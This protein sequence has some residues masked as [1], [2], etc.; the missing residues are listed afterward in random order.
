MFLDIDVN[1]KVV[2][3]QFN[4]A[5]NH[6]L[7]MCEKIMFP[8][9]NVVY[10]RKEILN[11]VSVYINGLGEFPLDLNGTNG[12]PVSLINNEAPI[13]LDDLYEKI[14]TLLNL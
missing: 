8:R 12:L 1:I 9:T 2:N 7:V 10:V 13:D 3:I 6:P 14:R 4:N 5:S 11:Y